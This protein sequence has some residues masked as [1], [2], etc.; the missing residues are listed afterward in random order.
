MCSC[1]TP[2]FGKNS[3]CSKHLAKFS[4]WL[5]VLVANPLPPGCTGRLLRIWNHA[6]LEQPAAAL[7]PVE[8]RL[9]FTNKVTADFTGRVFVAASRQP[10][11]DGPL[12]QSWFKP[13]PFFAQDVSNWKP[14]TP[15]AFHP[16]YHFPYPLEK[17][18]AGKYYIQAVMDLDRG[19]QNALTAAGNGFSNP[20]MLDLAE[21]ADG[22][23][24][25]T[26]D[27]VVPEKTF[28]ENERVKLV[29]IES[30]LLT[31][32]HGTPTRL[33]AGVVLPKSYADH[34]LRRYPVVYEIPGFGGDHHMAFAVASRQ[35]P[36]VGVEMIH[37]VLDPSCRLGHHVFADSANNG[38]R[39]RALIE[40]LIPRIEKEYRALGSVPG[41]PFRH[42]A[43]VWRLVKPVAAS[44]LPRFLR[45][46]LGDGPRS[47][48]FS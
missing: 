4:V 19:G 13:E 11:K 36:D 17:L 15:L 3:S 41:S 8:F 44:H 10:L 40:E 24:A 32:F 25:L 2:P 47:R 29:D 38:P 6:A 27:Q 9:T 37:V 31:A 39:G 33:R 23:I 46:R 45:G 30:R 43:F 7:R 1:G 42:R 34:P 20:H 5:I 21:R 35:Q 12:R 48:R 28:T 22:P 14:G 16:A 18:P 26:I